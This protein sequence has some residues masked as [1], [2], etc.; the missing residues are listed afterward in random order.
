MGT[1]SKMITVG[2]KIPPDLH[3]QLQNRL[4]G[5]N[6]TV[7]QFLKQCIV[8]E[9]NHRPD[10]RHKYPSEEEMV[11][12]FYSEWNTRKPIATIINLLAE[13]HD[14][15]IEYMHHCFG[16]LLLCGALS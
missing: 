14:V 5:T 1:N 2:V 7:P 6:K 15:S 13:R 12:Y 16:R 8:D 4:V 10:P 11:S 9:V 3:T